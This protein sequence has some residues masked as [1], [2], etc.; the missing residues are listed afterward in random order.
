MFRGQ[1]RPPTPR[2][3][4]KWR[5]HLGSA[6]TSPLSHPQFEIKT[7]CNPTGYQE[8]WWL[9]SMSKRILAS[10]CICDLRTRLITACWHCAG[11]RTYL[12]AEPVP[13]SWSCHGL[14]TPPQPAGEGFASS[15][16][17]SLVLHRP[18]AIA[19]GRGNSSGSASDRASCLSIRMAPVYAARRH[20]QTAPTHTCRRRP[21]CRS[22][23][24]AP[25]G[26]APQSLSAI[27][28]SARRRHPVIASSMDSCMPLPTMSWHP[29]P[30]RPWRNFPGDARDV[31]VLDGVA[32]LV[33]RHP[34][35]PA[36]KRTEYLDSRLPIWSS[37]G[38]LMVS[39]G[40]CRQRNM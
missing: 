4:D 1:H 16:I 17:L 14:H 24:H 18:S 35:S 22:S 33:D 2:L 3:C 8:A 25:C 37:D 36:R 32:P 31:G 38:T 34:L 11:L 9:K 12:Q 23:V 13:A 30:G 28:R 21:S 29:V 6:C 10:S 40:Q 15:S 39:A 5:I 26:S 7:T 27:L 19:A 20:Q